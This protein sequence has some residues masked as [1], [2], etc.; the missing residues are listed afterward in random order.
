MSDATFPENLWTVCK[1]Q[2]SLLRSVLP[3]LSHPDGCQLLAGA[4][5]VW[6]PWTESFPGCH[7]C[8]VV[9][10]SFKGRPSVPSGRLA[11]VGEV[12]VLAWGSSLADH[13]HDCPLVC[14]SVC[15][16]VCLSALCLSVTLTELWVGPTSSLNYRNAAYRIYWQ[17]PSLDSFQSSCIVSE[18]AYSVCL[19]SENS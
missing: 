4:D 1:L 12:V 6:T 3:R 10:S 5:D 14:Q 2:K 16:S 19:Q 18:W 7:Q 8:R 13:P 17:P 11:W 15:L 9:N